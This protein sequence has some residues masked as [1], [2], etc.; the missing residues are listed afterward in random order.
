MILILLG[1][2]GVGK[3]TQGVLLAE[4]QGWKHLSTGDLF[5]ENLSNETELGQQAK[6]FMEKGE[7]VPLVSCQFVFLFR[8]DGR[9]AFRSL[10]IVYFT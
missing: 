3:G 7:L 10:Q 6:S 8:K 2:P 4:E 5:R 1:P 9:V